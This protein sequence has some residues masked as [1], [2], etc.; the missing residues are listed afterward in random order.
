MAK[1]AIEAIRNAE[2]EARTLL[3]NAKDTSIELKNETEVLAEDKFN[4]ILEEAREKAKQLKEASVKEGEAL[5]APILQEGKKESEA[6]L[7][8]KDEDLEVAV[9]IIIERIVNT[10]GNS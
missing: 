9:N 4:E 2:A 3:Q 1:D 6:L 5:A 7:A 10:N 8:M